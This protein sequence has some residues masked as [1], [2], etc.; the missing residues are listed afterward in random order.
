MPDAFFFGAPASG[1]PR[2]WASEKST[3][4]IALRQPGVCASKA[5]YAAEGRGLRTRGTS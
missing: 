3:S 4:F 5:G 2:P 1:A